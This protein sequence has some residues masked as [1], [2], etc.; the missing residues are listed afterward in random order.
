MGFGE[1]KAIT[2]SMF[3]YKKAWREKADGTNSADMSFEE[4]FEDDSDAIAGAREAML[5]DDEL[6]KTFPER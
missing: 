5:E 2:H 1:L 6:R 4:F 3:P